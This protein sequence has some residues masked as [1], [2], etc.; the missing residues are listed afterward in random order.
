MIRE[1]TALYRA[2]T[3]GKEFAAALNE[4][5]YR[6][7]KADRRDLCI[8]DAAGHVHSIARRIEGVKASELAIFMQDINSQ[9]LPTAA[10]ARRRI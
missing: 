5:G 1:I 9:V 2:S 8:V 3:T 6:L 7:I 4:R 10:E